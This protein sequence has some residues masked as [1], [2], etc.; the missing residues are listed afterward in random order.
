MGQDS[1]AVCVCEVRLDFVDE[2][3]HGVD[4]R[5]TVVDRDLVAEQRPVDDFLETCLHLVDIARL[6]DSILV[7]IVLHAILDDIGIGRDMDNDRA[8]C[9]EEDRLLHLVHYQLPIEVVA[10]LAVF[11]VERR[12]HGVVHVPTNHHAVIA[13]IGADLRVVVEAVTLVHLLE[14]WGRLQQP[15]LFFGGSVVRVPRGVRDLPV[16]VDQGEAGAHVFRHPVVDCVGD[17]GGSGVFTP[18][19]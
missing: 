8:L 4:Q 5:A 1:A 10:L 12:V 16:L 3:G 9:E 14:L 13:V 18:S 2:L 11:E 17:G 7:G 6:N 19:E 15:L